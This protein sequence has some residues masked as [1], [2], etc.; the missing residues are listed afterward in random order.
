MNRPHNRGR[1][2]RAVKPANVGA[3][4]LRY[5]G[6]VPI[7]LYNLPLMQAASVLPF[8]PRLRGAPERVLEVFNT[9]IW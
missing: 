3:G 7:S 6:T 4:P 1:T 9:S 8:L 5:L 2:R